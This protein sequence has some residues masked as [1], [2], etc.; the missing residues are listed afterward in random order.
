[1]GLEDCN[2]KIAYAIQTISTMPSNLDYVIHTSRQC[3]PDHVDYAIQAVSTMR[4]KP[5]RL[6]DPNH[7]HY[8]A[9][10]ILRQVTANLRRFAD[11]RSTNSARI[12][13]FVYRLASN[14]YVNRVLND[15]PWFLIAS[16]GGIHYFAEGK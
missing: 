8:F 5:P 4:S 13:C 6:C 7:L 11:L 9:Q 10:A 3:D 15:A 1:M 12:I 14:R 16:A 2:L